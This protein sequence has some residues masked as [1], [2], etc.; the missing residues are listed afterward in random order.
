MDSNKRPRCARETLSR[1]KAKHCPRMALLLLG[2]GEGV[3]C[4]DGSTLGGGCRHGCSR[5]GNPALVDMAP[6]L[7]KETIER[8]TFLRSEHRR[9]GADASLRCSAGSG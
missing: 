8:R 1:L 9:S 4:R 3:R 2:D 6:L 5:G 7:G